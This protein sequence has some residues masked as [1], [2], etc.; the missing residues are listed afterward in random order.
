MQQL[1]AMSW[2]TNVLGIS[3][4]REANWARHRCNCRL[5]LV[6][7]QGLL[8]GLKFPAKQ[9]LRVAHAQQR[10]FLSA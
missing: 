8:Y 5:I 1:L 2:S 3:R 7:L 10:V 6:Q 9:E 4:E